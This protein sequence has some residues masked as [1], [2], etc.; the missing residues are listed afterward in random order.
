M[1]VSISLIFKMRGEIIFRTI[2]RL[3]IA[4]LT[5]LPKI[6]LATGGGVIL[7]AENLRFLSGRG[8]VR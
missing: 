1:G 7:N 2:E 5:Q 8:T 3:V 6:V 4:N